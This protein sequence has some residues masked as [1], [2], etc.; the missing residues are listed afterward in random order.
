MNKETDLRL[1]TIIHSVVARLYNKESTLGLD[2]ED[3]KCLEIIF[4]I[5]KQA[6]T[7]TN[8]STIE[9]SSV[10]YNLIDLLRAA[11][12]TPSDDNPEG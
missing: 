12:A 7:S 2:I 11:K 8:S 3:L 1:E 5:S 9:G 10:P 4:K 6:T